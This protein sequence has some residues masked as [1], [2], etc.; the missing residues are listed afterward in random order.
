MQFNDKYVTAIMVNFEIYFMVS[1]T[2]C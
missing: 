1:Y 2:H